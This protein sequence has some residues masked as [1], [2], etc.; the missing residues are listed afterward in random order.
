MPMSIDVPDT[1]YTALEE[2]SEEEV[3]RALWGLVYDQRRDTDH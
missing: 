2:P 3:E 1:L